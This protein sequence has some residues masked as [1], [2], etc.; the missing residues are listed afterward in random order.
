MYQNGD[1]KTP[2]SLED[3]SVDERIVNVHKKLSESIRQCPKTFFIWDTNIFYSFVKEI[4]YFASL[5]LINKD[6]VMHLKEELLQLLGVVEHLSIKGEFSENK[7]VS[8]YLSNISFEATYS[9][10]EK[11]DYQVSLLR[12]YSINSMDSQSSYLPD[13]TQLDS[14]VEAPLYSGFGKWRSTAYCFLAKAVG[15]YQYVVNKGKHTK[16]CG[17]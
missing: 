15:S 17:F 7:K 3:M 12:V 6:D 8:F 2:H 9:Y 14:I 11:H 16:H 10:I 1:I 5:N 13:A 4:K